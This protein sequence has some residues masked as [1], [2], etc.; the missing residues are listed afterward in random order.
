MKMSGVNGRQGLALNLAG[1][2]HTFQ[3]V[4]QSWLFAKES[5]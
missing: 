2:L 4:F 5:E 3:N 1:S